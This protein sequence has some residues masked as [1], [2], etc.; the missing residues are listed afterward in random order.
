MR[1]FACAALLRATMQ[2]GGGIEEATLAQCLVSAKA[3]GEQMSEAAARFL[4]WVI[5]RTAGGGEP[6]WLLAF[7]LLVVATRLR[8]GRV[9]DPA[10]GDA[11][12]WVL[13]EEAAERQGFI[14]TNPT[15]LAFGHMYGLWQPLAAELIREAADIHTGEVRDNLE[16]IG[17]CVLDAA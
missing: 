11:A 3:V 16:F 7:G 1:A 2:D 9:A 12:D 10:L 15:P 14:P 6:R 17:A 4:T 5:P 8:L 13:T